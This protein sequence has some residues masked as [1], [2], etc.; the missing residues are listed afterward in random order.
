MILQAIE[1]E[2]DDGST[3]IIYVHPEHTDK[4]LELLGVE[5]DPEVE[6]ELISAETRH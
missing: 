6:L 4:V 1:L 2:F 3:G 5:A